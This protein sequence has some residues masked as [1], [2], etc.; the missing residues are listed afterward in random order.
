MAGGQNKRFHGL[1]KAFNRYKGIRFLDHQL[2]ILT[3]FFEE[4]IVV[5]NDPLQYQKWNV[6]T[7][8]DLLPVRSSLTGVHAGLSHASHPY[9]FITACDTPLLQANLL[10][11]LLDTVDD[12][13]DVVI[14]ETSVGLEVLCAIYS[15][16]CLKPAEQYLQ[17]NRF[18]IRNMFR[19][20]RV[21]KVPEKRLR[22]V[23]AQL[24]SFININTP[25]DLA[26][27]QNIRL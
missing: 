1:N 5:T 9:A 14:P 20:L 10:Q 21:K 26:Q 19:E 6:K 23:D 4:I 22:Q 18:R 25:E 3:K 13:T 11:L 8:V 16:R 27:A 15:K 7:A 12:Q 17:Q 2:N 24:L